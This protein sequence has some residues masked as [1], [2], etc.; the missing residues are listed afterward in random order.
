MPSRTVYNLVTGGGQAILFEDVLSDSRFSG[1]GSVGASHIHSI[2]CAPLR[3]QRR[4]A[5]GLLQVDAQDRRNRFK[6][7]DL[8]FLVAVAGTIS[9]AIEG[10][11]LHEI[12]V[13]HG[14]LEQEARDAWTVQRSFIPERP[15]TVPGYEFWH[16]YEPA[17]FVGGD[18][19]DYLPIRI[20]RSPS[21]RSPANPG[22]SASKRPPASL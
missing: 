8:D 3:D 2:M 20:A 13:R 4:R 22:A 9:M 5:V 18:Y 11:R 16:H 21:P 17:R 1:S 12:E 6:S 19:F 7:E 14:K 15:P 10:A